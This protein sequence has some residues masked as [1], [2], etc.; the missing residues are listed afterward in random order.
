[1]AAMM[2]PEFL[3]CTPKKGKRID[4]SLRAI[5]KCVCRQ[6][7]LAGVLLLGTGGAIPPMTVTHME[8]VCQI[9][10]PKTIYPFAYRTHTHSLGNQHKPSP[11]L[12]N[13]GK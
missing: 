3:C 12:S 2:T 1:M 7:K 13:F 9:L 5:A 6:K 11:N 10:E 4:I 8:T